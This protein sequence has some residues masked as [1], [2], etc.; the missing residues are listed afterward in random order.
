MPFCKEKQLLHRVPSSKE[1]KRLHAT[2]DRVCTSSTSIKV[3]ASLLP[4]AV[5]WIIIWRRRDGN[6][7]SDRRW[8]AARRDEERASEIHTFFKMLSPSVYI[9]KCVTFLA[10]KF[11]LTLIS[12]TKILIWFWR[13]CTCNIKHFLFSKTPFSNWQNTVFEGSLN[14]KDC[15]EL[16]FLRLKDILPCPQAFSQ[17]LRSFLWR[18]PM[19]CFS[20]YVYGRQ[21]LLY[22]SLTDISS[23]WTPFSRICLWQPYIHAN[24]GLRAF[25]SSSHFFVLCNVDAL[26]DLQS[27]RTTPRALEKVWERGTNTEQKNACV[28]LTMH[29][30]VL[31]ASVRKQRRCGTIV[32]IILSVRR[33]DEKCVNNCIASR[34]NARLFLH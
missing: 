12:N 7:V 14:L 9:W 34:G 13:T 10:S 5:L 25:L 24:A 4:K 28:A 23:H 29:R 16:I 17:I 18:T 33:T 26:E 30:T 22:I 19:I 15:K 6:V 1:P 20:Q 31:K 3:N 2:R 27:R 32:R 21:S 11:M 8:M